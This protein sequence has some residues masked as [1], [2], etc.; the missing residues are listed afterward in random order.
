MSQLV[1]SNLNWQSR[2]YPNPASF[3]VNLTQAYR[4]VKKIELIHYS[5]VNSFYNINKFKNTFV[6]ELPATPT[7]YSDGIILP[8]NP[9][10]VIVEISIEP[11]NYTIQNLISALQNT[12]NNKLIEL[13]RTERFTINYNLNTLKIS[14]NEN[15][16][17]CFRIVGNHKNFTFSTEALGLPDNFIQLK[18]LTDW[19]SIYNFPYAFNLTNVGEVIL[20]LK[21]LELDLLS[22]DNKLRGHFVLPVPVLF[23]QRYVSS[24]KTHKIFKNPIT[25]A[26]LEI[27][28]KDAKGQY[29]DM[30]NAN[31]VLVFNLS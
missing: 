2:Y 9:N 27:E 5:I 23:G 30:S 28:F 19:N 15:T 6:I 20:D 26:N 4:N 21:N 3:I 7:A 10:N 18:S 31:Y 29:L 13:N 1:I 8:N 16:N 25:I 11:Q 22:A 14:M 24:V 17:Y 12:L